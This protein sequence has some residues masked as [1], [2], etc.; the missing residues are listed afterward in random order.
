MGLSSARKDNAPTI[1]TARTRLQQRRK[2]CERLPEIFLMPFSEN[3][4]SAHGFRRRAD[5]PDYDLAVR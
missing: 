3:Q 4:S 2:A 5:V 1:T